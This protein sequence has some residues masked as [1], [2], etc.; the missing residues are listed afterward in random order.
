MAGLGDLQDFLERG[1]AA[2]R[3]MKGAE[4]FLALLRERET[5]ILNRLFSSRPEPFSI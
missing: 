1:F 2:F 3:D 4:E 5:T